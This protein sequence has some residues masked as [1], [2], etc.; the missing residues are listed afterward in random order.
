MEIIYKT[1]NKGFKKIG[2][3]L[4]YVYRLIIRPLFPSACRFHPTCSEYTI[5]AIQKYGLFKGGFLGV[6][7]I[8]RCHGGN[9]G[10][11]DGV[12]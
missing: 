2:I 3:V 10:G 8:M 4:V 7:R 1:I 9:P 6:K 11:V 5:Q 12:R